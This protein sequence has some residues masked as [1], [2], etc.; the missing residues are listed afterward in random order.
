[1]TTMLE[2]VPWGRRSQIPP[3]GHGLTANG[4]RIYRRERPRGWKVAIEGMLHVKGEARHS[5]VDSHI[6]G[7]RTK[8]WLLS[9]KTRN[10]RCCAGNWV[11]NHS[12]NTLP[13]A[14]YL[15][16]ISG[17][18]HC[19]TSRVM[20]RGTGGK[21]CTRYSSIQ[22]TSFWTRVCQIQPPFDRA[23]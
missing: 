4:S 18:N 19:S 15:F 12:P 20:V 1:M 22:L 17:F 14:V 21:L 10:G 3:V 2:I 16:P 6:R 5:R 13:S 7:S 8:R 11:F 23:I 9:Q